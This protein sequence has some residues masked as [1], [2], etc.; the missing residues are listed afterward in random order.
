MLYAHIAEVHFLEHTLDVSEAFINDEN[1]QKARFEKIRILENKKFY[2]TGEFFKELS[3][4]TYYYQVLDD[5]GC[6]EYTFKTLIALL[7]D[8]EGKN[9]FIQ[10]ERLHSHR[11]MINQKG[12]TEMFM[13]ME[14]NVEKYKKKVWSDVYSG[15]I[16][17]IKNRNAKEID[18]MAKEIIA[19]HNKIYCIF[20][21]AHYNNNCVEIIYE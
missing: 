3:E 19:I 12:V 14:R 4:E 9:I 20:A 2:E 7:N 21:E 11:Y 18:S 8:C 16:N 10:S 13:L 17:F 1:N 15:K 6:N 5:I